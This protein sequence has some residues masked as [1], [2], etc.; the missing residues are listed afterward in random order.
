MNERHSYSANLCDQL[1]RIAWGEAAARI[2]I[3]SITSRTAIVR[4]PL[5]AWDHA[6]RDAGRKRNGR[7]GQLLLPVKINWVGLDSPLVLV[8]QGQVAPLKWRITGGKN[9]GP[10]GVTNFSADASIAAFDTG[11][12][13]TELPTMINI[14]LLSRI[15]ARRAL[16]QFAADG[17]NARWELLHTLEENLEWNFN[18]AMVSVSADITRD[19]DIFATNSLTRVLDETSS[20]AIKTDIIYGHDGEASLAS[21]LIDRCLTVADFSRYDP[22]LYVRRWMFSTAETAIR[23]HIG[24]PHVGRLV[25][26]VAR[27]IKSDDLDTVVTEFRRRYPSA[28]LGRQRASDALAVAKHYA[29]TDPIFFENTGISYDRPALRKNSAFDYDDHGHR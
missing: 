10:H 25:R 12:F 11:T 23:R 1:E 15:N 26:Q 20:E 3:R 21:N 22:E 17:R 8:K 28:S 6:S 13:I 7:N 4:L 9:I 29:V 5:F 18:R 14:N 24:D 19:V 2:D 27:D 16:S